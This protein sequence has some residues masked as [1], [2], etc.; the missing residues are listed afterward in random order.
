MKI[1]ELSGPSGLRRFVAAPWAILDAASLPAWIPPLRMSVRSMLD[2]KTNPL[3][4][5]A[6]RALF[7][8]E[9]SGRP[10]GRVAAILNHQAAAVGR[11]PG[12][13]GFFE[14][15]DDQEVASA[16][17]SAAEAWLKERGSGFVTGPVSPSTNYEGGVLIE[18]FEH[19]Q[20]F[21]TP[22]NPPY[23]ADLFTGAG[24]GKG[25]DLLAWRLALDD[26]DGD[27][28]GR[29]D[30][31]GERIRDKLDVTIGPIDFR[32]FDS[33]MHGCWEVYC[34]CWKRQ[35]GFM[36]LSFEEWLFIAHELKPLMVPEGSLAV[37]SEGEMVAFSLIMPD[38]GRAMA[39]DRSGRLLP[40]NWLRLL[41]AR[42]RTR[43]CRIML[44]GVLPRF[45]RMGG[46]S[47]LLGEA[48]RKA[49]KFGVRDVEASWVL[50]DNDDLNRTLERV[51][52]EVYRVWRVFQKQI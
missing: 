37:Y 33:V 31:V 42:R 2:P 30:R 39:T 35:W 18:G 44:A 49:S 24:Y 16:L 5:N 19:P 32:H 6:E 43:W 7:L 9:E 51:G 38:Y 12:F 14:S 26:L 50:E 34:E 27:T 8:A 1:Q 46:L 47:L 10:V 41:R 52:G 29:L 15:V 28:G 11:D 17:L 36:P 13:V 4:R 3:F 20:T 40:L 45:R 21:M 23:Y 48:L 22:W 25:A